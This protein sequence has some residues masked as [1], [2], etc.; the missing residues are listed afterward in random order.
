[1]F[2][3]ALAHAIPASQHWAGEV[4]CGANTCARSYF[5]YWFSLWRR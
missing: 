5:G 1:M 4:V 2:A 3:A